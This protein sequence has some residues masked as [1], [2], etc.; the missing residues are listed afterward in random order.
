MEDDI[1]KRKRGGISGNRGGGI[2]LY[3]PTKHIPTLISVFKEG[4]DIAA[5]CAKFTICRATFTNWVNRNPDFADAYRIARELARSWWEQKAI[6]HLSD[7]HFNQNVWRLMMRN[8]FDMT[9]TRVVPVPFKANQ[10]PKQQY[11]VLMKEIALGNVT[12]EEAIKLVNFVCAGVKIEESTVIRQD[13][14]KLM[15]VAGIECPSSPI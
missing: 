9:D 15:K 5:F 12:P 4:N 11:E 7:P 1:P 10:S 13:L 8:R 2:N 14:D 3:D 6:D